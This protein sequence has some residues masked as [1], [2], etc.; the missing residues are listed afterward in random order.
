M[1]SRHLSVRSCPFHEVCYLFRFSTS[2]GEMSHTVWGEMSFHTLSLGVALSMRVCVSWYHPSADFI[3]LLFM[4]YHI[5]RFDT[6]SLL[7][8]LCL[9]LSP[10]LGL[11]N[12][13]KTYCFAFRAF[14]PRDIFVYLRLNHA[15]LALCRTALT[16]GTVL[17]PSTTL[18]GVPNCSAISWIPP[19]S[20]MM[21]CVSDMAVERGRRMYL[22]AIA[23]S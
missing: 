3:L 10:K 21:P 20:I 1:G 15:T 4:H 14:H 9:P 6:R 12:R 19:T 22:K 13:E 7:A 23:L 18:L 11:M 2:R 5:C 8:D 17:P 16:F